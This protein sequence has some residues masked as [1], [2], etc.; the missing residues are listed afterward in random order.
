MKHLFLGSVMFLFAI[1]LYAQNVVVYPNKKDSSIIKV[2]EYYKGC[3][4]IFDSTMKNL[5]STLNGKYSFTPD[6][7]EI[8]MTEQL[9][10]KDYEEL[11]QIDVRAKSLIGTRYKQYYYEYYRQY[12]GA[13]NNAGEK[14]IFIQLFSCCKKNI[15]K[16]YPDWKKEL[17][18]PL[19]ENVCTI[20]ITFIVNLSQKKIS[21]Y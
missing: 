20:T 10:E 8:L 16:C 17:V 2:K 7:K 18:S 5:L 13:V 15:G 9:I 12:A 21:L 4:K 3:G 19:D 1:N 6:A 11:L 14:V